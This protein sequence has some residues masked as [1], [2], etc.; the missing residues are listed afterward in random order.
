MG[1][2]NSNIIDENKLIIHPTVYA[3]YIRHESET[4][5]YLTQIEP[6]LSSRDIITKIP[7][8]EQ[9]ESR[10]RSMCYQQVL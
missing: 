2:G 9:V 1:E 8:S 5:I 4:E 7:I 10:K 6:S 3:V